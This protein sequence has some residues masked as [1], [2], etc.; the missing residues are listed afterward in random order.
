MIIILFIHIPQYVISIIIPWK[1]NSLLQYSSEKK[2]LNQ[3]INLRCGKSNPLNPIY[4]YYTGVI[5]NALTGTDIAGI[6]GIEYIANI[7]NELDDDDEYLQNNH[8][9][10]T[11]MQLGNKNNTEMEN[12]YIKSYLSKKIFIYTPLDNRT[13]SLD[14]FRVRPAA[15]KRKIKQ[16]YKE[17]NELISMTPS[18]DSK[19]SFS[20]I[21]QW[22]KG[23]TSSTQK[24]K[25]ITDDMYRDSKSTSLSNDKKISNKQHSSRLELTNFILGGVPKGKRR[26]W[27]KWISFSSPSSDILGKS[28][29]YY[30]IYPI[31]ERLSF[32]SIFQKLRLGKV[33]P[34]VLMLYRRYG[35]GPSWYSLGRPSLTEIQGY[36]YDSLQDTPN[37]V[38][39]LIENTLKSQWNNGNQFL[40]YEDFD[41]QLDLFDKYK[42]WYQILW[43]KIKR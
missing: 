14:T 24:L 37:H 4:W 38:H 19:N 16:V 36:R 6:E 5:K 13:T 12:L 40:N 8:E 39:K 23:R 3:F 42:P 2:K 28:Q 35:E 1:F 29:E 10:L 26:A 34:R 27:N 22:P 9:K 21:I 41:Q 31:N 15:P 20:V 25:I 33:L 7:H 43:S 32:Q 17:M 30:S 11:L 18:R